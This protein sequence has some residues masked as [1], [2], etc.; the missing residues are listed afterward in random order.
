MLPGKAWAP[1]LAALCA[2]VLIARELLAGRQHNELILEGS[3]LACFAAFAG[4]ALA[5]PSASLVGYVVACAQLFQAL[6]IGAFMARRL[7][8]TMPIVQRVAPAD[9][10]GERYF[11][12]FNMGLSTVWL[13]SFLVSGV[14][15]VIM[16]GGGLHAAFGQVIVA[17][18]SVAIPYVLQRGMLRELY[19]SKAPSASP[20]AL[21]IEHVHV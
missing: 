4:L 2:A 1:A 8:F 7:P 3:T 5:S 21:N 18:A 6:V 19:T 16:V 9:M 20:P 11:F 12:R 15:L 10:A 17:L 13:T 14:L